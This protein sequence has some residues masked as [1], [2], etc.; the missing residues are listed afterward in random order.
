MMNKIIKYGLISLIFDLK[1]HQSIADL[2]LLVLN[3]TINMEMLD[4]L[5]FYLKDLL[6]K[7]FSLL[8][9]RRIKNKEKV[10]K[11]IIK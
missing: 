5:L 6:L 11:L 1:G 8:V 2:V 9:K 3:N 7:F 10:I 4:A